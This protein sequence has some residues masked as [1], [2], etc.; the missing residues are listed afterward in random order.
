MHKLVQ[1]GFSSENIN[2]SID[3]N[4][5]SNGVVVSISSVCE[6]GELYQLLMITMATQ[7]ELGVVTISGLEIQ[8]CVMNETPMYDLMN[9]TWVQ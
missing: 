6:L 9:M 5:N 4:S 3:S 8:Y 7:F 1:H 2:G